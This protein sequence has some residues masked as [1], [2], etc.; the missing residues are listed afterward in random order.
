MQFYA[1]ILFS[2][3]A[4]GA[5]GGLLNTVIVNI[6]NVLATIPAIVLVD[7][8]GRRVLLMVAAAWM[9]VAQVIVAIVLAVQ[10]KKYGSDL[11]SATSIGVLVMICVYIC[12]HAYGWGPIGW[13]YPTEIQ[14]LETRAA[15]A[16]INTA[17][18][19]VNLIPRLCAP[20][21]K[22]ARILV[23]K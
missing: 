8:V 10:F 12:G 15:G 11:P 21:Q 16:G 18:N 1:P 19:M 13:L 14:P 6:V 3:L 9:F 17:S 5:L 22:P 23:C 2:S 4:S 7:R 20:Q